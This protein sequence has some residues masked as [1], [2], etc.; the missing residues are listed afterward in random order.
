M[1]DSSEA[2][3]RKVRLIAPGDPEGGSATYKVHVID[4]PDDGSLG[5][6]AVRAPGSPDGHLMARAP[7][8]AAED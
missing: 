8:P 1:T 7:L 3:R 6:H 2:R 4:D 5:V